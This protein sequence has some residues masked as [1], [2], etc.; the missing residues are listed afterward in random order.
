MVSWLLFI[1]IKF[2][3]RCPEACARVAASMIQGYSLREPF[4]GARGHRPQGLLIVHFTR[5]YLS[6]QGYRLLKPG[7]KV[8]ANVVDYLV[9]Q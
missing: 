8:N 3:L 2:R 9:K 5:I 7:F 4:Y 1:G 6:I